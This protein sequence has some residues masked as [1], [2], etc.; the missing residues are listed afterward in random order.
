MQTQLRYSGARALFRAFLILALITG[1]FVASPA[2]TAVAAV[3]GPVILGGDDLTD[4]G[5]VDTSSG[6]LQQGWLYLQ[7]ALEN[8]SPRVTRANTGSIAALGSTSSTE[9]S[10][11]AGA[12]VGRAGAKAGLTVTYYEGATA[13]NGF[14]TALSAGAATPR[15]IWIAGTGASNDL[16]SSEISALD[17]NATAIADFVNQ[18]GGLMS[19][20]TAYGWL[21]ALLPGLQTV[22][23]G[24]SNDLSLTPAGQAAF[25]G[26]TNADVNA[27]PWHNYFQGNFGGLQVLT[28]SANKTDSAGNPAAVIIGGAAVTLPGAI[29]LSPQAATNPVGTSHTLTATVRDTSG[30]VLSGVTV[31]FT[32]TAGPNVGRTGTAVTNGSGQATFTYTDTGGAGTDTI[33]ASFVSGSEVVQ[34]DTA[35]KTWTGGGTTPSRTVVNASSP[36]CGQIAISA[37]GITPGLPHQIVVTP[38]SGGAL[39][40]VNVIAQASG[41]ANATVDLSAA[42][43]TSGGTYFVYV[44]MSS[45]QVTV[46]NTAI[47]TAAV[48]ATTTPTPTPTATPTPTPNR[49]PTP[50]AIPAPAPTPT[51]A[52]AVLGIARLPSTSTSG[53]EPGTVL[54]LLGIL[55]VGA[56]IWRF[57]PTRT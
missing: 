49:T 23:S 3:G 39:H 48:C 16:D 54:T 7:R 32:V 15:I 46:S 30:A 56:I 13:I 12:A 57:R 45:N 5:S 42:F 41:T 8:I 24:S 31:T 27:G 11:D 18:G 33:Q 6:D 29:S 17:A 4:H 50:T 20:G 10:D 2:Q 26:V 36:A 22:N 43:G 37:T 34:K 21:Q 1:G 55:A 38:S 25:P 28:T 52:T 40:V 35:T 9:T 19:H 53:G 44:R 14:F 51:P 47:V